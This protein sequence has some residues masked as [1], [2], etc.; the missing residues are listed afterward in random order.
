MRRYYKRKDGRMYARGTTAC[1]VAYTVRNPNPDGLVDLYATGYLLTTEHIDELM[2]CDAH[3]K[4]LTPEQP[5]PNPKRHPHAD[6]IHAW[7]EGA[8]IQIRRHGGKWVDASNPAFDP[9][10]NYRVKPT[11]SK[12]RAELAELEKRVAEE[13]VD[14]GERTLQL[15]KLMDK[16][17]ALRKVVANG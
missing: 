1:R 7:A 10:T 11:L 6:V 16:R 13:A 14:I 2:E 12:E 15:H 4:P 17:D 5:V 9:D 8:K 3:G